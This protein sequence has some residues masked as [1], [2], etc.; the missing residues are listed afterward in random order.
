M[1]SA[2][3]RVDALECDHDW[4]GEIMLTSTGEVE[5]Q[6]V[7]FGIQRCGRNKDGQIRHVNDCQ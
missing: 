7:V 2:F 5:T 6:R 4:S 1:R 3:V